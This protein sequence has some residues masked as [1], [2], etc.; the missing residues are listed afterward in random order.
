MYVAAG[1]I[2]I[3]Y[4][5]L[6]FLSRKEAV[7]PKTGF[8]LRPFHRMALHLYKW[9][10]IHKIP[11][12]YG[13]QVQ[14]DLARLNPGEVKERIYTEYYV[15]KLARSLLVCL[16]GMFLGLAVSIS[17][18]AD[19]ILSDS[20]VILRE[21]YQEG[22]KELEVEC[23]LPEGV[24]EFHIHVA[25]RELTEEEACQMYGSFRDSLMERML[26]ENTSLEEVSD[27]LCLEETYAGY[28]FSVSWESSAPDIISNEGVVYSMEE[29][30]REVQIL[31]VISYGD[32]EWEEQFAV[33]VIPPLLTQEE[34]IHREL[35][36]LLNASEE[37]SRKETEWQLPGNWQGRELSWRQ[38]L[39]DNGP[40]LWAAA[41]AV[42][43]LVYLL[44]DKDLHDEWEKRKKHMRREYPDLVHKLVLYLGAGMTIRGGFQKLAGDYEQGRKE[45]KPQSPL[46]EEVLYTCREL[47]AGMSEGAAYEHFGKRTGLQEYI[48]LSTLLTQNL[49]KGNSTLLQRLREEADKASAERLQSG[50]RLAEEAVTKL[51][52]PMV[53]M[54][55]VVM[56]MIM[57]PAFSS[58]GG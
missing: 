4:L 34:Q 40:I 48:R 20:G 6:A 18:R 30:A 9:F 58:V 11:V 22:D 25:A 7:D 54:L 21:S 27:N 2:S 10:C 17:A 35:E 5:T 46:Y 8:A 31:A 12:F 19:R 29:E 50:K 14:R 56:L 28:P 43:I 32:L 39:R 55:L 16:V 23:T 1:L 26:G 53:M 49:K 3:L 15:A 45:G 42:A 37:N 44:A 57:I 41:V 38:K 13:R 52:L 24:Q 51:L 36:T 47:Q 33:R